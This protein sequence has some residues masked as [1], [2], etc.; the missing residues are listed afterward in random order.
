MPPVASFESYKVTQNAETREEVLTRIEPVA[1]SEYDTPF[2]Y[3]YET[4]GVYT[5]VVW[6]SSLDS[7]DPSNYSRNMKTVYVKVAEAP[8]TGG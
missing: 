2:R 3:I 8:A 1:G 7:D 4:P 6:A 5:L